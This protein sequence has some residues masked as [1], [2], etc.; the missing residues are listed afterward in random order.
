LLE[1]M[2]VW[3]HPELE[4]NQDH[5][6]EI[7][8]TEASLLFGEQSLHSSRECPRPFLRASLTSTSYNTSVG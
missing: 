6:D 4:E 2:L 8:E 7:R 1:V 3:L 5:S